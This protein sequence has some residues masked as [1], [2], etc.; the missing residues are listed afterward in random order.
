LKAAVVDLGII[1]RESRVLPG[2]TA[3]GIIVVAAFAYSIRIAIDPA[4]GNDLLTA[5]FLLANAVGWILGWLLRR[6]TSGSTIG[7]L[8][9]LLGDATFPLNLFAPLLLF[10]PLLR[11]DVPLVASTVILVGIAYHLYHYWNR[12]TARFALPF[13]GYFFAFTGGAG[14][15]LLRFTA[16]LPLWGVALLLLL[17]AIGFNEFSYRKRPEPAVHFAI[18]AASILTASIIVS[19]FAFRDRNPLALGAMVI[20]TIV[21]VFSATRERG[22]EAMGR[23]H[24]LAAW[25]GVTLS[26]T[27]MLYAVHTPL[28]GYV[29]ATGAWTLVL[30]VVSTRVGRGW[31]DPFPE[32]AW[33]AAMLLSAALALTLWQEWLPFVI[34]TL[35]ASVSGPAT[36]IGVLE[37]GIALLLVSVWRRRH[38]S[39]AATLPGFVANNVLLR[40]TSYAAPL[41]LIVATA[42]AWSILHGPAP[43]SVYA[44]LAAGTLLLIFSP[45]LTRLYPAEALDFAGLLAMIFSAFNG[46]GSAMLSASV[47]FAAAAIS[48]ARYLRSA[49]RWTFAA[50]LILTAGGL[51]L[52]TIGSERSTIV[53]LIAA[54]VVAWASTRALGN[55]ARIGFWA[56]HTT[57]LLFWISLARTFSFGPA[58]DAVLL[59]LWAWF[60]LVAW[61][62]GRG[63]GARISLH[64]SYLLAGSSLLVLSLRPGPPEL[65]IVALLTL[66]ALLLELPHV[67][68][69]GFGF[70]AAA[71]VL[72][73]N[74]TEGRWLAGA[75]AVCAFVLLWRSLMRHSGLAHLLF[76]AAAAACA[77]LLM[78]GRGSMQM[79]PLSIVVVVLC[80]IELWSVRKPGSFHADVTSVIALLLASTILAAEI[81]SGRFSLPVIA[82]LVVAAFAIR[83]WIVSGEHHRVQPAA[84]AAFHCFGIVAAAV[85]AVAIARFE[86][87]TAGQQLLVFALTAW[88]V[89]GWLMRSR[90]RIAAATLHVIAAGVYGGAIVLRSEDPFV[91]AACIVMAGAYLVWRAAGKSYLLEHLAGLGIVEAICLWGVARHVR[92]PELYLFAAAAYLCIVLLRRTATRA[93]NA[94]AIIVIAAAIAYPYYALLRTA[95]AEHLAFLGMASIVVIHVL[96]AARRNVLMVVTVCAMLGLGM[97]A[98]VILHDDVRLNLLMALVGFVVIADLGV[99]GIRS[100][101]RPAVGEI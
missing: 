31:S 97:V 56:A 11:G 36:T 45:R 24:A 85:A 43:A 29:V 74:R 78:P 79:M 42:G 60:A 7:F 61:R 10:V 82:I 64:V 23:A 55:M 48:L 40:L 53:F 101:R 76:I 14:L 63:I 52:Q 66:G 89:L 77:G 83:S 86:G 2:F 35:A 50:F 94:I 88:L 57:A 47:L 68:Y 3:I 67:Q 73:T 28:W 33:W 17:Y 6:R 59:A 96:L 93:Q 15:V 12:S 46:L 69:G 1:S 37:A 70:L 62:G 5:T 80:V 99:I 38:P 98:G 71:V 81:A 18:A 30:A 92:W 16:G 72:A 75:L 34:R 51:A 22:D 100:D 26:F 8:L 58:N 4:A 44:P 20:A 19:A 13:Y 25:L 95:R 21:L 9:V 84:H 65:L 32:S 39:I 90:S 27:A 87:M 41:F 49:A 91:P 54:L